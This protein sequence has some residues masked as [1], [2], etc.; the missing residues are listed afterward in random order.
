VIAT[1]GAP[2][3]L[4]PSSLKSRPDFLRVQSGGRR[5]RRDR[6]VV[7]VD[8]RGGASADSGSSVRVGYT[9]SRRVGNAVVRNRVRRRLREIVRLQQEQL[10]A[11]FDYVIVGQPA[12]AQAGYLA[13]ADELAAL[14]VAARR[15]AEQQD[16]G[17][18]PKLDPS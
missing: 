4:K 10:V 17:P 2:R 15:W 11:G 18:A 6:I 14:L 8:R 3:R 5:F 1:P 13:L 12:A 7:L 16:R 9:V